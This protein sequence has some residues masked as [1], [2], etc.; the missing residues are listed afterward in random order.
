MIIKCPSYPF[1]SESGEREER[2][3]YTDLNSEHSGIPMTGCEMMITLTLPK[4]CAEGD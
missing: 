3:R 2:S 1:L 4:K